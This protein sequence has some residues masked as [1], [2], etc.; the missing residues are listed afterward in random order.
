TY[1]IT[2]TSTQT[3]AINCFGD[4]SAEITITSAGG[5][6]AY[7]YSIDGTNFQTSSVFSNLSAGEYDV[8]SMDENGCIDEVTVE[9]TQPSQ[10]VLNAI[11]T[12][13]S[14]FGENNGSITI[15][16]SGGTPAYVNTINSASGLF[17][18]L[19]QGTYLTTT[20]DANGCSQSFST[21]ITEPT[22]VNVSGVPTMAIAGSSNGSITLTG[23]GGLTPYTYSIN[24]TNYYSGSFFAN[25]AAGTYTCYIK[26]ANGCINTT[27]VI[28]EEAAGINE[29]EAHV[30]NLFPNPN[31]GIF[32]LLI[33][34][35]SDEIVSFKLFNL[36]GQV[37]SEFNL[38][39]TNGEIKQTIEMGRRLSAGTYY[40]GM[41]QQN[42]A[43]IKQFI[44]E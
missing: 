37:V 44:K 38:K 4:A 43:Q 33:S 23:S 29:N 19:S 10:L 26:D 31:N 41:Y 5:Q 28:V 27:T 9:I 35:L 3:A 36:S 30:F 6:G 1:S 7:T 21:T 13:I 8:I 11:P 34:G 20:T 32:E 15:S 18:E 25:L 2:A 24:G 12:M 42:S 40:L 39:P 14:C 17:T 22:Q 16:V